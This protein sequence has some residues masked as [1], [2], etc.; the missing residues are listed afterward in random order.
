MESEINSLV[1]KINTPLTSI[2]GIGKVTAAV[3]LGEIHDPV[4]KAYY[5]KKRSEGKHHMVAT[6]AVA[7]KPFQNLLDCISKQT[8]NR[9]YFL[10]F[11]L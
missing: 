3:I 11:L 6:N 10:T 2:P 9:K 8:I 7:R 4:F 1:E 5:Q